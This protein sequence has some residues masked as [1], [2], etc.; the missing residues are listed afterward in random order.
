MPIPN[1]FTEKTVG[2]AFAAAFALWAWMLNNLA[3]R[4]ENG[5]ADVIKEQA[6]IKT[7]I[8]ALRADM[9]AQRLRDL[10]E[11][12]CIRERQNQVLLRLQKVDGLPAPH[13][14]CASEEER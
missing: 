14:V 9:N 7:E 6:M 1:L 8:S 13:D 3:E 10:R 5:V 11:I 2:I 4:V 12:V